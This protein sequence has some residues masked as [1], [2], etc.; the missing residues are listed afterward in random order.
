MVVR[1]EYSFLTHEEL[2]AFIH[3]LG[4]KTA[5]EQELLQ[6]LEVVLDALEDSDGN[7]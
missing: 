4:T 1:T 6:R 5:L 2:I 7:A 3:T